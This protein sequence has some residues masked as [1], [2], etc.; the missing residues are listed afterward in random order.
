MYKSNIETVIPKK[1][2]TT[3]E[4]VRIPHKRGQPP[5]P[6]DQGYLPPKQ[7]HPEEE[8]H[9]NLPTR[10]WRKSRKARLNWRRSF[11][12]EPG[13]IGHCIPTIELGFIIRIVRARS[14]VMTQPSTRVAVMGQSLISKIE[15]QGLA[16]NTLCA[17]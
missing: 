8:T 13:S 6:E 2:K 14:C 1:R 7:G 5:K 16:S 17:R 4:A 3:P 15:P 12:S 9:Q 10:N 11:S